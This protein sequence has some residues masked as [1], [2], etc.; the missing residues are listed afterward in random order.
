MPSTTQ[1]KKTA[2]TKKSASR[3]AAQS[4]RRK[5]SGRQA[6]TPRPVRREVG[7]VVCLLLA[8]FAGIGYFNL[9]GVVINLMRNLLCGLMGYGFWFTPPAFLPRSTTSGRR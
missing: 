4:G 8:F 1:K 3:T 9:E 5:P 7:A 6:S 2:P